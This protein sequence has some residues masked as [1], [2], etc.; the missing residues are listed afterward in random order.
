M[1]RSRYDEDIYSTNRSLVVDG[2]SAVPRGPG[3]GIKVNEAEV[4][5]PLS[6]LTMPSYLNVAML[7]LDPSHGYPDAL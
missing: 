6:N 2:A 7:R 4:A 3:L 1:T 5:M